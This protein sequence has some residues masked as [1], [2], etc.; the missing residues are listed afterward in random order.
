MLYEMFLISMF[1]LA[2]LFSTIRDGC[3]KHVF[4]LSFVSHKDFCLDVFQE[5]LLLVVKIDS[6]TFIHILC[7]G[8]KTELNCDE[9]S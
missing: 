1:S 9:F 7:I 6:Q 5:T 8:L 4:A 2:I 3:D